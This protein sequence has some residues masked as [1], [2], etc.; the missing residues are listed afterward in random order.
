MI[1]DSQFAPS[2]RDFDFAESFGGSLFGSDGSNPS[3][4]SPAPA[5]FIYSRNGGSI[6]RVVVATAALKWRAG[7]SALLRCERVLASGRV[8][9]SSVRVASCR[10]A[11]FQCRAAVS[12]RGVLR[13]SLFLSDGRWVCSA[14]A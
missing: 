9:V 8:V 3:P 5:S 2:E 10:A 7:S 11:A 6:G 13:A 4:A 14:V 1:S 12:G